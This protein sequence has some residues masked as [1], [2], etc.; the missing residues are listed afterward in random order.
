[1]AGLNVLCHRQISMWDVWEFIRS[2]RATVPHAQACLYMCHYTCR[3]HWEWTWA[4][5]LVSHCKLGIW[6]SR[7]QALLSH[8]EEEKG[9]CW[10][11][12]SRRSSLQTWKEAGFSS[13]LFP[14]GAEHHVAQSG[15]LSG[16]AAATGNAWKG[17]TLV[18]LCSF[19]DQKHTLIFMLHPSVAQMWWEGTASWEGWK[20]ILKS[21]RK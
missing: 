5:L 2:L 16:K 18:I 20:D 15:S 6:F 10:R 8:K 14:A 4:S 19:Q 13:L 3:E 1:M 17:R 9:S 21:Q 12:V 11:S 7:P